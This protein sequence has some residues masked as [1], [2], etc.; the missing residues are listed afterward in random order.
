M[1]K[2]QAFK[3]Y[4]DARRQHHNTVRV[5]SVQY[6]H[7]GPLDYIVLYD[8]FEEKEFRRQCRNY[9]IRKHT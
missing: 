9:T 2:E 3:M 8:T 7:G 6:T 4:S 5:L 1:T